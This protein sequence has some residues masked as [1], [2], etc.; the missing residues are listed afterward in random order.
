[1]HMSDQN[2]LE[3]ISEL[4]SAVADVAAKLADQT[5][6]PLL[7]SRR[8][9]ARMLGVSPSTFD[10]AVR[11]GTLPRGLPTPGGP[12]WRVSDLKRWADSLKPAR[13]AAQVITTTQGDSGD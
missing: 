6:P 4:R 10:R 2:I 9:G 13:R 5:G 8:N 3:V 1:M 12:R 7:V 11:A